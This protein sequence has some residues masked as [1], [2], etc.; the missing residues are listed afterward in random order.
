LPNKIKLNFL[1]HVTDKNHPRKQTV[2]TKADEILDIVRE[3]EIF[4]P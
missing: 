3:P 4:L 1:P 2:E